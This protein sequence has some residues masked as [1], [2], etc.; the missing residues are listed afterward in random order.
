MSFYTNVVRYKNNILYRGYDNHGKRVMRKDFFQPR[1]FVSS[2]MKNE[3]KGFDGS[4]VAPLDFPSMFE[5]NQWIKQN[6]GVSGRHI[7]GNKKFVQQYITEKFPRDIEFKRED[8]N[9]GTFDIETDYD[10]GFP[11][12]N[13]AS[14]TVLAITYKSSKFSTYHVW[15]YGEFLSLIHI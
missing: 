4:D 14:Q 10:N 12:A 3:W 13:E 6:A 9:V 8:I 5:A 15:G 11:H 7:Y 2:K 1:L